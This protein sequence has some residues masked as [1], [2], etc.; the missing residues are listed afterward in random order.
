MTFA[1]LVLTALQEPSNDEL[2][3]QVQELEERV[4][5]LEGS[6]QEPEK[7]EEPKKDGFNVKA[8][9][10]E[11]LTIG[12]QIRL[13]GEMRDI[14]D[15]RNPGQFGRPA[16]DDFEDGS[17]MVLERTRVYLDAT[18]VKDLRAFVQI[19]DART[20]GDEASVAADTADLDLK[21]GWIEVKNIFDVPFSVKAGRIEVP[22]LGDGRLMSP[23][24]WHNVGRSWDGIHLT[25]APEGWHLFGFFVNIAD[26]GIF[27]GESG[28]ADDDLLFGGIYVSYRGVKDHEFD[29]YAFHRHFS[30]DDFASEQGG[31]LGD[32]QDTTMGLRAKGKLG[33]FDYSG[34]LAFQFG[35]QAEDDVRS[36]ALALLL[37]YTI[38]ID[39]KPRIAIEYAFAGGDDDPADGD[40]GTFDP[41]F[42]FGH[43]YHG[44]IDLAGWRNLHSFMLAIR[45]QPLQNLSVHLDAHLFR[46]A[47]DADAW[48]SAAGSPIRRDLT[49]SSGRSVGG[50]VDVYAK[51]K[52][53]EERLE[54]WAGYSHFFA[55]SFVDDTGEDPDM[56]W[57]FLQIL[58]NL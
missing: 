51:W 22:S 52:L 3:K 36:F 38:D 9:L 11:S 17:D 46:L 33:S 45:I 29:G 56:D 14:A 23:L 48:Y 35:E 32:R 55:G 41:L 26:G 43:Y 5:R 25:Y 50:E 13:R 21:Q 7:K 30:D 27:G 12:G 8:P 39:W 19:Q 49:G 24:D 16:T 58:V 28:D 4:K 20:W 18:I 37:G 2:K 31:P 47:E 15:Y 54:F 57:V 34:E 44:H 10:V 42:P 53:W 40:V 6:K 1:L